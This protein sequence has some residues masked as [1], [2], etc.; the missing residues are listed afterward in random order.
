MVMKK[1]SRTTA[2]KEPIDLSCRIVKD[3]RKQT[4][5]VVVHLPDDHVLEDLD[6][7]AD[8]STIAQVTLNRL[9]DTTVLTFHVNEDEDDRLDD[10]DDDEDEELENELSAALEDDENV[11][12]EEF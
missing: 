6:I 5:T 12:E 3:I 7:S 9:P 11:E 1:K 10:G 8:F 2:M 4:R